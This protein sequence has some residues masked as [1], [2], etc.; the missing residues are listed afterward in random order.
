M[1]LIKIVYFRNDLVQ[2]IAIS[3][4]FSIL[5]TEKLQFKTEISFG[6]IIGYIFH[7]LSQK[8]QVSR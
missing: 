5:Q 4:Y 2:S 8:F 6:I 7:H 3:E 1:L